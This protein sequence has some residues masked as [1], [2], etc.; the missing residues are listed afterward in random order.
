MGNLYWCISFTTITCSILLTAIYMF[1]LQIILFLLS[2][3][4]E[5]RVSKFVLAPIEDIHRVL[6]LSFNRLLTK[7]SF[8]RK[9][10]LS[11][12][13]KL[14]NIISVMA[15]IITVFLKCHDFDSVFDRLVGLDSSGFLFSIYTEGL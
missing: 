14:C 8:L 7:H 9:H 11:H 13:N 4:L 5:L 1:L 2:C 15:F 12:L 10:I 6:L 3:I